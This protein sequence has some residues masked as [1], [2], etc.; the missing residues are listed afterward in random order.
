MEQYLQIVAEHIP[1]A[2][3]G[4]VYVYFIKVS[5]Q[6]W[7]APPAAR[8]EIISISMSILK[9]LQRRLRIDNTRTI[10]TFEKTPIIVNC[11]LRILEF[12]DTYVQHPYPKA[13]TCATVTTFFSI[14]YSSSNLYRDFTRAINF[15]FQTLLATCST[16]SSFY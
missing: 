4:L 13:G 2:K 8:R 11:I 10:G 16:K 5:D 1:P 7:K 14:N 12:C 6:S 3:I 9:K 15:T